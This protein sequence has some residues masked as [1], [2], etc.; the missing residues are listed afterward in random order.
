LAATQIVEAIAAARAAG[1]VFRLGL[2]TG[3][4]PLPT[5]AALRE[6]FLQPDSTVDFSEVRTFNLDEYL[7]LP[8]D[9]PESYRSFM[10]AN[11]FV[12]ELLYS[13]ANPRG[14]RPEH[15][16]I[17]DGQ[18]ATS[19]D[20][21]R[22]Y[23]LRAAQYEAL[24]REQGP[25]DIQILGI[26]LNGHIGF[27]EPGAPLDGP[28][29]CAELTESTRLANARFFDGQ[30]ELVPR[31]AITMGIGSIMAARHII[32]IATGAA[33]APIIAR[34]LGCSAPTADIPASA[35]LRHPN[36]T[37]LLDAAASSRLPLTHPPLH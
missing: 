30:L 16:H 23:H 34:T 35:L 12:P 31:H 11:L 4:T 14:F 26:G 37:F 29:T 36:V 6:L 19:A 21:V 28:T 27:N 5:Y 22:E 15:I 17:P 33:K 18:P 10:F 9:H 32:L 25:V 24:L 8:A 20:P 1:Q 3:S 7:D 2:A 13:P